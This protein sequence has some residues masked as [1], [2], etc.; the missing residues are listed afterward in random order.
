MK[1]E[2]KVLM[3]SFLLA[4]AL[5]VPRAVLADDDAKTEAAE[6]VQT[7]KAEQH[8]A[9]A[10]K[11]EKLA[12]DQQAIID[13]HT[14]MKAGEKKRMPPKMAETATKAMDKHCNA[15]INAAQKEKAALSEFAKWHKMRAA[16]LQGK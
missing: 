8:L 10:A 3:A 2:I 13:E 16:E 5:A 7:E 11:Y 6:S 4:G 9:M 14:A 12:A 15:L 1:N